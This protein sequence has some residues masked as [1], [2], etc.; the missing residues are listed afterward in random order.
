MPNTNPRAID[1][2][3]KFDVVA[4]KLGWEDRE[5]YIDQDIAEAKDAHASAKSELV[6]Y[7]E[8]LET[9]L[10]LMK[11]VALWMV[12]GETGRSSMALA[13]LLLN[14]DTEDG[15]HPLDPADLRRC[16]LLIEACDIPFEQFKIAETLSA[17]WE[18]LISSWNDICATMDAE[19]PDWRDGR[20]E[21]PKTAAKMD[22]IYKQTTTPLWIDAK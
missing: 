9:K 4:K 19:S 22:E 12:Q 17:E 21:A 15:I 16:R 5:G 3:D 2:I 14:L 11:K 8:G 10:S 18:A 1:L 20:G 7:A 6:E 13:G